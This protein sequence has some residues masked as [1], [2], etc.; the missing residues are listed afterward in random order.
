MPSTTPAA[1]RPYMTKCFR[2]MTFW[3]QTKQTV[4]NRSAE[5]CSALT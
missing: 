4:K 2:Q 5:I 1:Q 3:R